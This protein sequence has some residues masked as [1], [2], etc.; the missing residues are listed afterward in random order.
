MAHH[1]IA[2]LMLA[3][4]SAAALSVIPASSGTAA[5]KKPVFDLSAP[6]HQEW[7]RFAKKNT[8]NNP[9]FR[10]CDGGNVSPAL[11]WSGPP[12]ATKSFAIV[13]VDLS[14]SPPLGVAHWVAYDIAASKTGL[15]EGEASQPSNA[16]KSGKNGFGLVGYFGPCPPAGEKAHPYTFVLM[17][18]D[19]APGTLTA[20]MTRD[21]LAAALKGHIIGRTTLVLRAGG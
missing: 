14:G 21:E 1:R 18:T 7:S 11:R 12:A 20:G 19:L 9:D 10:G 2:G 5:D 13:L 16:F 4:A 17:A 15:N 8:G 3:A 6:G